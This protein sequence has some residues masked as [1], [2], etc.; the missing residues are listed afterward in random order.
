MR[1]ALR[2]SLFTAGAIFAATV[3]HAAIVH[4]TANLDGLQ[5][6]PV[7]ASPATGVAI[8]VVDTDANTLTYTLTFSGLTSGQTAAHIHGFADPGTNAGVLFGIGV[9][10]P[11]SNTC[12]YLDAQEASILAG[13]SYFNVHTG[14]FSGGEIRGQLIADP[15]SVDAKTWS[16]VKHLYD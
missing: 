9:G 4:M 3:A 10:S 15:V 6:V 16:Q 13:Q 11:L 8:V 1:F 5:E 2:T 12:N 7:N 14:N